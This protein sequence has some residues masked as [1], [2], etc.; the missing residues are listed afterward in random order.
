MLKKLKIVFNKYVIIFFIINSLFCSIFV[1]FRS[2]KISVEIEEVFS[3]YTPEARS[4]ILST[5]QKAS[6]VEELRALYEIEI[7]S[8]LFLLVIYALDYI[9]LYLFVSK[10]KEHILWYVLSICALFFV[11]FSIFSEIKKLQYNIVYINLSL[12]TTS[13][14]VA[15]YTCSILQDTLEGSIIN[16][17]SLKEE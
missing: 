17:R 12:Y 16:R 3:E 11:I 2:N 1:N 5:S 7:T 9:Y 14:F 6:E 13:I 10:N 8:M 15:L 4:F